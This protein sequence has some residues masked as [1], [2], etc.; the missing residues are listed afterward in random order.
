MVWDDPAVGYELR[1]LFKATSLEEELTQFIARSR[2]D[3]ITDAWACHKRV[4]RNTEDVLPSSIHDSMP[5]V[6]QG[7]GLLRATSA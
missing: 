7:A 2:R 6:S 5:N 1:R 4:L 3:L